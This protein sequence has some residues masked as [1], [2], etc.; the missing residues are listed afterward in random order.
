M[1]KRKQ[2]QENSAKAKRKK[3]VER[4]LK[5]FWEDDL[6]DQMKKCGGG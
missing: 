3:N 2:K 5:C 1:G 6:A 4:K